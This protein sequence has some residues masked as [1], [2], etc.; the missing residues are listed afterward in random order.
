MVLLKH[1]YTWVFFHWFKF[2][3]SFFIIRSIHYKFAYKRDF[4]P[5]RNFL[6]NKFNSIS[7]KLVCRKFISEINILCLFNK[8]K[9]TISQRASCI[10]QEFLIDKMN[11]S[12]T[13]HS[14]SKT[15]FESRCPLDK[16]SFE[17]AK[18]ILALSNCTLFFSIR[19]WINCMHYIFI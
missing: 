6:T 13:R 8:Y 7:T 12:P 1:G 15:I 2:L 17:R 4:E 16:Y 11:K 14:A 9:F 5:T 18:Y 3:R 10:F 19:G